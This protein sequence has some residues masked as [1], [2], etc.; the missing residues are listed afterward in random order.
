MYNPSVGVLGYPLSE[1]LNQYLVL[2]AKST[3]T[4]DRPLHLHNICIYFMLVVGKWVI[5]M[6]DNRVFCPGSVVTR[7]RHADA[8]KRLGRPR[9][10]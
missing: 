6:F 4:P 8:L 9:G 3:V 10:R 7:L 2:V 1:W 5:V